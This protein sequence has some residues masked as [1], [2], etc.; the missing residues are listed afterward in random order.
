MLFTHKYI[1]TVSDYS[2][3]ISLEKPYSVKF[4]DIW[5]CGAFGLTVFPLC[6]SSFPLGSLVCWR[7]MNSSSVQSEWGWVNSHHKLGLPLPHR[8]MWRHNA[9]ALHNDSNRDTKYLFFTDHLRSDS[10]PQVPGRGS[11][12]CSM[13]LQCISTWNMN[14]IVKLLIMRYFIC[15]Q[16]WRVSWFYLSL[17]PVSYII[18]Y[19]FDKCA[20]TGFIWAQICNLS[21]GIGA[22]RTS[23]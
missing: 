14:P 19:F 11:V 18:L 22:S 5:L 20:Y 21:M 13:S 7:G 16:V 6:V 12:S 1:S 23:F 10:L 2:V 17:Y 4:T 15:V 3:L 9:T 8:V